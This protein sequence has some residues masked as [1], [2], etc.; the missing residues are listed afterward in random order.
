MINGNMLSTF[1]KRTVKRNVLVGPEVLRK[2]LKV[3]TSDNHTEN[4][5]NL[6][7]RSITPNIGNNI[8]FS[9]TWN[10]N[11]KKL[12]ADIV[13][14]IIKLSKVGLNN[15]LIQEGDIIAKVATALVD[16]KKTEVNTYQAIP[17][18]RRKLFSVRSECKRNLPD[19]NKRRNR[20]HFFKLDH[21]RDGAPKVRYFVFVETT[22]SWED[23]R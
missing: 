3:A 11:K 22:M 6:G 5:G 2:Y 14:A 4:L 19:D 20:K 10:E 16:S 8:D 7:K 18:A 13:H 21:R 9:C 1:S 17:E 12:N 15:T 23:A